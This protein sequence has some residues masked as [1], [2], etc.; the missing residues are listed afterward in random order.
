M[1]HCSSAQ[2]LT[3]ANFR[4][5]F[6]ILV[7]QAPLQDYKN[8]NWRQPAGDPYNGTTLPAPNILTQANVSIKLSNQSS[9]G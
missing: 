9:H 4:I 1:S 6:G 8:G 3:Y 7:T 2:S 5:F